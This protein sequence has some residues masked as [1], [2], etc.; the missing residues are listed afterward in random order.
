MTR[1]TSVSPT[2]AAWGRRIHRARYA[3]LAAAAAL[4]ALSA[5][6]AAQ[7]RTPARTG[8]ETEAGRGYALLEQELPGTAGATFHIVFRHPRLRVD[9]AAYQLTLSRALAPLHADP[10]VIRVESPVDGSLASRTLRVSRD[11]RSVVATVAV[12]G[13]T[14]SAAREFPSLRAL[15]G[16]H[17][18]P[19]LATGP[20]ALR[21]DFE[22]TIT[23]DLRRAERLTLPLVLAVLMWVFGSLAAATLPLAIA[24]L[25][26]LGGMAALALLSRVMDV[27]DYAPSVVTLVGLGVAIDYSL[28]V[29]ARFREEL[30]LGASVARAVEV[31]VGTAGRAVLFSGL[32][33]AIG[34]SG[35]LF[36][37]GTHLASMGIA[38]AAVTALAVVYALTVLPAILGV[39]GRSVDA[40]RL[41]L[42]R[43]PQS[44]P[45]AWRRIATG[46]MAHPGWVLIPTLVLLA[47]TAHPFARISLAGAEE[48]VIPEHTESR[49][50]LAILR[51][52][53]AAQESPR[54]VLV[55]HVLDGRI[56][57]PRRLAQ[58]A[59]LVADVRSMSS[60]ASVDNPVEWLAAAPDV[61]A[62][63]MS[64]RVVALGVHTRPS[65]SMECERALVHRL[66]AQLDRPSDI[67]PLVTGPAAYHLDMVASI[68]ASAPRA[69]AWVIGLTLV[70]VFALLGSVALPVKAVVM[71]VISIAA[72]FGALVW[73]FQDGHFAHVLGFRA[74]P[75]DPA[76][77]A[78]L[79]CLVFGFSMDYEV[80]ILSRIHE[81]YRQHGDNRRAVVEGIDRSAGLVTSAAAIMVVVFA[82]FARSEMVLVKALGIGMAIAV[83]LDATVIRLLVVPATMRLFGRLNWWSP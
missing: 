33:V 82:S 7:T 13:S 8:T 11:R 10:R 55:A 48:N 58:L 12:R 54:V 65:C 25:S 74:G 43:P 20:L 37:R 2:F 66:R 28:F 69:I 44:G 61:A 57:E 42:R 9:D 53:F 45:S 62:R 26:V 18:L 60:V 78:I 72:S 59:S 79:F 50:G 23:G 75:I 40:G 34:L 31:A 15:V 83:A 36:F 4:L 64:T 29:T 77:P 22:R 80:L 39:L 38:G 32:T 6:G 51:S 67:A 24:V 27:S 63:T 17:G 70:A 49:Q 3:V 1:N 68:R 16:G 56:L 46:V 14:A 52:D 47:A 5:Y 21:H 73:I 41:R 19:V 81:A 35:L 76:L 30:A 71:N